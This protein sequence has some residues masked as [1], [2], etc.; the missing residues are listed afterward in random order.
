MDA[1]CLWVG[2]VLL[3]ASGIAAAIFIAFW[4]M[5]RCWYRLKV[6]NEVRIAMFEIWERRMRERREQGKRWP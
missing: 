6:M 4:L 2:R 1:L 5:D 3:A